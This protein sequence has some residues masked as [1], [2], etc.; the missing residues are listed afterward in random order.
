MLC[1]CACRWAD[2]H[3]RTWEPLHNVR[4]DLVSAWDQEQAAKG[5]DLATNQRAEDESSADN[6]R[7]WSQGGLRGAADTD[8]E[9]NEE[10]YRVISFADKG[11]LKE[12][13]FV[14][15]IE[16]AK[17]IAGEEGIIED[18]SGEN[19]NGSV[20][21]KAQNGANEKLKEEVLL[22]EAAG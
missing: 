19:G 4:A 21:G 8:E 15:S 7:R 17:A 1:R 3:E 5:V 6:G 22:A 13:A 2:G 9:G 20:N 16:E 18:A 11:A 12:E 10:R 14:A